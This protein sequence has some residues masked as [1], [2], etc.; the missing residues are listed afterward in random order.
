MA[1]R[2][3][4]LSSPHAGARR[5]SLGGSGS[6]VPSKPESPSQRVSDEPRKKRRCKE[7]QRPGSDPYGGTIQSGINPW[8]PDPS[9]SLEEIF[10]PHVNGS[11][12]IEKI[13]DIFGDPRNEYV[14]IKWFDGNGKP[15]VEADP[16][17]RP[18]QLSTVAEYEQRL[19]QSGLADDCSG[20]P[21]SFVCFSSS[22]SL[23]K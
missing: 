7:P 19:F 14:D 18:L 3:S 15:C 12:R 17:N 20:Q 11:L 8:N 9:L 6:P 13:F 2:S 23:S 5:S 16:C 21:W 10:E 1:K 22:L 4:G